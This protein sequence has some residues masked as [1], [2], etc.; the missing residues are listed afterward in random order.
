MY[1][2]LS[3]GAIGVSAPDLDSSIDAARRGGFQG[4]EVNGSEIAGLVESSGVEV[5]REKFAA[6]GVV[7]AAF[8]L[9]IDWRTTKDK[10]PDALA[11][12]GRIA[13][14]CEAI[15]CNRSCTWIM[16][17]SDEL[18]L[19]ANRQVHIDGLTPV[20]RILADNG[21]FLGLE[22]IGPKTLRDTRSY[23]FIY[24]MLPMLDMA[25][26]I[27]PMTGLLL[28][29]WHWY[30]SGSTVDELEQLEA[31]DVVY[32]HVNDAPAG[33]DRDAQVD[34]VRSLP[35]STGVIDSKGFMHALKKIGYD[36]PVTAE[37]FSRELA[38]LP[39]DD[40]RLHV[41]GDS[42]RKLFSYLEG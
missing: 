42:M 9:P 33:I 37:P 15:G 23:P 10:L 24:E 41:V 38:D 13:K 29:A 2:A 3:P 30:T 35:A 14:A 16:P 32:V 39:T 19:D 5:V 6:A 17:C 1:T 21:C 18:E 4:V 26:E 27:G 20:A 11:E 28:D 34:N 25:K 31:K 7:P 36:G 12:L 8:G 40:D 22:F